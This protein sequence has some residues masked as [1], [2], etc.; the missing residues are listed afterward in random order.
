MS[1]LTQLAINPE[2]FV[3]DPA[4]G[5]VFTVNTAGYLVLVGLRENRS[6]RLI[7]R[8]LMEKYD[9]SVDDAE[10][11]VYD[12]ISHLRTYH[13]IEKNTTFSTTSMGDSKQL[14]RN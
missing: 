14:P 11:D 6:P 4:F 8:Q 2:G 7:A 13:L 1:R 9:I 5:E 3:F 10:K 12:F